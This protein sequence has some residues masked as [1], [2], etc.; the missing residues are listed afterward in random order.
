[1][2]YNLKIS[3]SLINDSKYAINKIKNLKTDLK[4]IQIGL[5]CV[6]TEF[7][8]KHNLSSN[9]NIKAFSCSL[10]VLFPYKGILNHYNFC[11]ANKFCHLSTSLHIFL[12]W[13]NYTSALQYG[14]DIKSLVQFYL[15]SIFLTAKIY[16]EFH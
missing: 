5:N 16:Y 3:G 15:T 10:H 7:H 9:R 4:K 2:L 6:I 12:A 1:M 11:H 14:F 13:A 8:S